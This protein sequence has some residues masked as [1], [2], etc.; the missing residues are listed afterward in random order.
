[1]NIKFPTGFLWG[2]STS[3]HQ[4]EGFCDNNWS[5][6]EKSE[7]RLKYLEENKLIEKYGLDNFISG[8][9]IDDYNR[10]KEDILLL[11]QLGHKIFRFTIEWS[12]VEP[13]EGEVNYEII[14]HYKEE[15]NFLIENNIEPMICFWHWTVP[16][17]FE[18]K[19]AFLK[20]E[21][22][23]YF[24]KFVDLISKELKAKYYITLNEPEVFLANSYMT[25]EWPPQ[26]KNIFNAIKVLFN[27]LKA[28]K[29]SY[30]IIKQNQKDSLVSIAKH[31][32]YF[33]SNNNPL[34]KIIKK[35]A[36]YFVNDF[37]LN[38]IKNEIDFIG[39][40]YYMRNHINFF[41]EHKPQ[42]K[43]DLNWEIYPEGIHYLLKDLKKYNKDIIITEH[44]LAGNEDKY[45]IWYIY[46]TI[47]NMKKAIDEDV[48]LVGYMHWSA[49]DNFEWAEGKWPRFGLI[50]IDYKNN[51]ERKPRKSA[52]FFRDIIENNGINEEIENKYK[53]EINNSI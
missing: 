18:E 25:G 24:E 39:L 17:W 8:K 7:K 10:F 2:S 6:W 12:K 32:T 9:C 3:S 27:L 19:G 11:K 13:K 36:K 33:S 53:D 1:M 28:H 30:K 50:E 40:N 38:N 23:K 15:L 44:G 5:N 4:I 41:E 21:N 26:D 47:K 52:Y 48:R 49:F 14:N 35:L 31:N 51:L 42:T 22:I 20:K 37:I 29:S 34:H 46:E 45:R 16:I 43:N